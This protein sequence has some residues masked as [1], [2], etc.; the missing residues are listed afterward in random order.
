M[1]LKHW[2]MMNPCKRFSIPKLRVEIVDV[3]FSMVWL[4]AL[5]TT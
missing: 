3:R 1:C 4:D 2:T 5:Y